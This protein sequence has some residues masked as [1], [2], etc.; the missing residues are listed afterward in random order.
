MNRNPRIMETTSESRDR[1]VDLRSP[2]AEHNYQVVAGW[3]GAVKAICLV[4]Q[5]R[6]TLVDERVEMVG[7]R[8]FFRCPTCGGPSLIHY[9]D[10]INLGLIDAIP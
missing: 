9:Q 8:A 1:V 7:G 6:A 10:S 2:K 4:C 3:R 5:R